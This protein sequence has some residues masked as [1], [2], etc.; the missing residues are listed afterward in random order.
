MEWGQRRGSCKAYK[1]HKTPS[2]AVVATQLL[3]K[4]KLK[5]PSPAVAAAQRGKKYNNKAPTP[6]ATE[7]PRKNKSPREP[8]NYKNPSPAVAQP[9]GKRKSSLTPS[10]TTSATAATTTGQPE[11]KEKPKGARQKEDSFS[12]R[13]SDH[14]NRTARKKEKPKGASQE[15]D[16]FSNSNSS[17]RTVRKRKSLKA[18]TKKTPPPAGDLTSKKR[19][20]SADD[21]NTRS[22]RSK[23]KL[24]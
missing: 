20:P 9:A 6:A 14:N 2:P 13:S 18:P 12:N 19:S 11:K 10:L 3:E 4:T 22:T 17:N 23:G 1:N 8:A 21:Q 16:S 7:S 15:K 24:T 5:T